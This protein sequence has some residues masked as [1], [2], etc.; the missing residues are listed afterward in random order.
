MNA[1]LLTVNQFLSDFCSRSMLN[2]LVFKTQREAN[3]D[4]VTGKP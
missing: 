3:R 2:K 1:T 4:G